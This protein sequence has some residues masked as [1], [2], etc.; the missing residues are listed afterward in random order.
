MQEVQGSK[1]LSRRN[2]R[3]T[4]NSV[5]RKIEAGDRRREHQIQPFVSE[6]LN[7][8]LGELVVDGH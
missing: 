1:P 7:K 4:L 3:K 6:A 8:L 5:D 2:L